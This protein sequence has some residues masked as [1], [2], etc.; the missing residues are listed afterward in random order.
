MITSRR[1]A[2]VDRN[3]SAL[4]VPLRAL[5]ESSGNAVARRV[6]DLTDPGD[7]VALACGRGNNGGDA[8]VAARFLTDRDV[9]VHL[10][11]RPESITTDVARAN[12]DALDSAGIDAE[13]VGDSREFALDDPDLIVDAMLGTGITGD[14]REPESS[15]ARAITDAG[16]PVLAVD[17]DAGVDADSGA[18]TPGAVDAEHVVTFHDLKPGLADHPDVTVADIGIPAAAEE[19]VGPGD[20]A[21]LGGVGD[22]KGDSGRTFVI[23]GGPYTGAPALAAGASLSAGADL[24][25]VACPE[26]VFEPIAGYSEDLIV[27]PYGDGGDTDDAADH[28]TPAQVPALVDTA[29]RHDDTVVLGP[30]LGR[31]PETE[32]A[33]R[34]FLA[35]YSGTAVVDA[36]ALALV[37][38][39][40]TDAEL[41]LTPNRSELAELGGPETDD[42]VAAAEEIRDLAAELGHTVLAKGTVD[43]IT[44]GE[45]VRRCRAGTPGM[46]VGG[47]G[48]TLAG[49]VAA[50]LARA[51]SFEAAC[52]G[53]YVNGRAAE[54]LDRG[55]GLRATE[56]QETIPVALEGDDDA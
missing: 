20:V 50:L 55:K 13:A 19:V 23:G 46:T 34:Q 12:W 5:M 41:L 37:P 27:Q 52:V 29:E 14:L 16:A 53:S 26:S 45:T 2:A 9:R 32:E 38:E 54:L 31:H 8:L 44:D 28:L 30:G 47:T 21:V 11:G 56:L 7:R 51:E 40:D 33:A 15:V 25:F 1:M 22:H 39:V 3:A 42:L 43:V 4:G 18:A 10:L 49:V 48:D 24:A 17:V 35:D 36:D 6:R